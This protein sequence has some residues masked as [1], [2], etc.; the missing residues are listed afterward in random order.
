MRLRITAAAALSVLLGAAIAAAEVTVYENSFSGRSSIGDLRKVEGGKECKRKWVKKDDELSVEIDKGATTCAFSTPVRGD[1]R[2]P[3]H[4]L[5]VKATVSK[6]V[7]KALR[8]EVFVAIS[9]RN[10]QSTGYELRVFPGTR[11]WEV[12]RRPEAQGFPL[13]ATDNAIAGVGK[14]NRLS[15]QAFGNSIT[16]AVNGKR[17]VDGMPDPGAGDVEGRRTTIAFGSNG[18]VKQR[19]GTRF[20]D[21]LI[22]LPNP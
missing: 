22:T 15:L 21:L 18:N 7:P 4:H 6:E 12:R 5:E 2:D 19:I 8:D 13:R 3:D 1:A 20:D 9:V 14:S 11:T 16:A 10:N 17:V